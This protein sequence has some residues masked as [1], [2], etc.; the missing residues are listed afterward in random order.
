MIPQRNSLMSLQ[1]YLQKFATFD[2][3]QLALTLR[4]F[5]DK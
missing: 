4:S 1:W 3:S 5:D 2:K